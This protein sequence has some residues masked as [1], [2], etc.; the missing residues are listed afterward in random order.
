MNSRRRPGLLGHDPEDHRS[1]VMN[2]HSAARDLRACSRGPV[3]V[4]GDADYDAQRATWSGAIDP[5][6]ALV[7]EALPPA[8][9]Q[10]AV[11][12][13]R[14]YELPFAAQSTGHGTQVPPDGGLLLKTSRMAEVL[15]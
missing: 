5:R 11:L 13:A 9:V 2:E 7:A 4:P 12:I 8:D 3:H 10:N 15:V 14:Q 1:A 6:P